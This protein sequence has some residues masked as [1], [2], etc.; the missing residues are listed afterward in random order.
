MAGQLTVPAQTPFVQRSPVVQAR[1]SLHMVPSDWFG[2]E[3]VPLDG[4]HVP[5][6]W[7]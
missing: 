3:Q 2:F 5:A 4:S 7:H 1:L 6:R